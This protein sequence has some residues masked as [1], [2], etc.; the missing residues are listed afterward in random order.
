M[1]SFVLRVDDYRQGLVTGGV[2]SHA[3]DVAAGTPL[4]VTLVW[5]DF[6]AALNAAAK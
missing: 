5:S 1:T 6:P 2:V 3:Y 4:R